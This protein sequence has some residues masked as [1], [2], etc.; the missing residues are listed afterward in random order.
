MC[1]LE[2]LL[3]NR[4]P[5]APSR[6]CARFIN[7]Y[8]DPRG[9]AISTQSEDFAMSQILNRG[10]HRRARMSGQDEQ[11]GQDKGPEEGLGA[12]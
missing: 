7:V 3:A 11:D 12:A 9:F 2:H 8:H 10:L 1:Y 6:A 5:F 4:P